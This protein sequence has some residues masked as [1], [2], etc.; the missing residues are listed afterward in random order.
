M[1]VAA[2]NLE[3]A[4]EKER[5]EEIIPVQA[6]AA[7][8]SKR[9]YGRLVKHHAAASATALVK[10]RFQTCDRDKSVRI[11]P[12]MAGCTAPPLPPGWRGRCAVWISKK[13]HDPDCGTMNIL[14]YD[15]ESRT[16]NS[17]CVRSAII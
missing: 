13:N 6:V 4:I 9:N 17:P 11:L 7:P 16:R 14:G 8:E 12:F 5:T 15:A 1:V 2:E 3:E 10:S